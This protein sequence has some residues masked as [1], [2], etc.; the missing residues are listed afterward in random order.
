MCIKAKTITDKANIFWW[1]Q[2]ISELTE[3]EHIP[4]VGS[5][6]PESVFSSTVLILNTIIVVQNVKITLLVTVADPHIPGQLMQEG[7]LASILGSNDCTT[8]LFTG[9]SNPFNPK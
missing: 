4:Q 8:V 3:S 5:N 6:L 9:K 2:C 7:R 1:S